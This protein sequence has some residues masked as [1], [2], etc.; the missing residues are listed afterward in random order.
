MYLYK[1]I[2][3]EELEKRLKEGKPLDHEALMKRIKE[4]GMPTRI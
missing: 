2:M 1:T 4:Q 3:M